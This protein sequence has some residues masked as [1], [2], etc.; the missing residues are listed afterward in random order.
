MTFSTFTQLL[1]ETKLWLSCLQ[2]FGTSWLWLECQNMQTIYTTYGFNLQDSLFKTCS[3]YDPRLSSALSSTASVHLLTT[4]A[5][6]N[7]ISWSVSCIYWVQGISWS[8]YCLCCSWWFS[9]KVC[10]CSCRL[11][12][13]L[14]LKNYIEL[15]NALGYEMKVGP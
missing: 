1:H 4:S 11:G 2:A 10:D 7:S 9:H 8:V 6:F 3:P 14:V 5:E 15:Q 13:I 12:F